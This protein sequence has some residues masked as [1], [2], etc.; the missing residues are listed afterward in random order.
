MREVDRLMM[1]EM[2]INLL[3]MMENAGRALALQARLLMAGDA[4]RK[5]VVVLAGPGGNGG[6]GL[7][8][9]RRLAS[10]GA[11][12]RVF[13]GAAS[14]A[15]QGVPRHQLDILHQLGLPVVEPA[16]ATGLDQALVAADVVLDALIG[17][18]LHGAPREP[19]ASY[20]R[21]ANAAQRPIIALDIPS[22]LD[23][24]TGEAH[25][26][27]IM[28]SRTLTL[29]LPK[30]GLLRAAAREWVGDLY[31]A[32]ISVPDLVYR[33]L[34]LVVGPIFAEADVVPIRADP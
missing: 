16:A 1:E 21:Q 30:A 18:S 28:A 6:G 17:Y 14:G 32:D 20:I 29:A 15:F 26:P 9:A 4:R 12:V 31:L 5:G 23:G 2:G 8:A 19:I 27:T 22:G 24:D 10:W 11:D 25:E 34:G 13:L 7:T 33:R 3:Q